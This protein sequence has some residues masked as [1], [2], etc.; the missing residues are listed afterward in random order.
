LVN[1]RL[2]LEGTIGKPIPPT[3]FDELPEGKG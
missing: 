2:G 3:L 1:A